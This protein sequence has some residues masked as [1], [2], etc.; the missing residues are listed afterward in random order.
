[1]RLYVCLDALDKDTV[2]CGAKA[3]LKSRSDWVGRF[4]VGLGNGRHI[5]RD[6]KYEAALPNI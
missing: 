6:A 4:F 3:L 5:L 1:M 2:H